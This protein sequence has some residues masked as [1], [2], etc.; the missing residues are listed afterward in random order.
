MDDSGMCSCQFTSGNAGSTRRYTAGK[1]LCLKLCFL[2]S[3]DMAFPF[4][5]LC[6]FIW[7]H[8]IFT[9]VFHQWVSQIAL[10]SIWEALSTQGCEIQNI[11]FFNGNRLCSC[12]STSSEFPQSLFF[13][14]LRQRTTS[15]L[16]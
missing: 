14:L 5:S 13:I 4:S 1:N 11:L 8:D 15:A 6:L 10:L 7:F 12:R 9:S 2:L 3:I 16:K